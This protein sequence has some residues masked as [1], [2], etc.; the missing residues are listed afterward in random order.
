MMIRPALVE[1]TKMRFLEFFR[2]PSAF[3]FVI[4]MP[5]VWMLAL[6]FA[7]S[8]KKDDKV[9]VGVLGEVAALSSESSD[10]S[11]NVHKGTR[12]ELDGMLKRGK[13]AL[14]VSE[15]Q[16]GEYVFQYDR[17]SDQARLT[18][19]RLEKFLLEKAGV[20]PP[21]KIER[22]YEKRHGS[23][24]IDFLIPG[25]MGFSILTSSLFGVGMTIVSNRRNG[26][27]KRYLATPMKPS[28]Y[29]ISHVFG[30]MLVLLVEIGSILLGGYLIFGFQVSGSFAAFSLLLVVG[31]ACF[32]AIGILFGARTESIGTVSGLINLTTFLL[33]IISGVFFQT[34]Y[35]PAWLYNIS[36]FLPLLPLIEGLRMVALEGY[37]ISAVVPQLSILAAY[38]VIASVAAKKIFKWF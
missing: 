24:Y 4:L 12:E 36:S 31:A 14:I 19:L 22:K 29:M 33:M 5:M 3:I 6:G 18:S 26:L 1:Q 8:D 11:L 10:T 23:R 32:T 17:S 15:D 20:T 34:H 38:F 16:P 25:L 30:R 27:F 9:S 7:F 2:E 13:I 35:F 28:D 21:F 37:G